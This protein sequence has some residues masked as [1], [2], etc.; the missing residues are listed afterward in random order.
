MWTRSAE[1]DYYLRHSHLIVAKAAVYDGLTGDVIAGFDDI[2]VTTGLVTMDASADF[3]R[4]STLTIHDDSG[5]K[6]PATFADALAPNG[7]EIQIWRGIVGPLIPEPELIPLGVFGVSTADIKSDV[8]GGVQID[9][10]A[11]DRGRRASLAK[12]TDSYVVAPN[13]NIATAIQTILQTALPDSLGI[14]Y[15][16]APTA[17]STGSAPLVY[18]VGDDPWK[19]ATD[20]A[21]SVGYWLY[22]NGVGNCILKPVPDP[23][24]A[25]IDWIYEEG[26][27]ATILTAEKKLDDTETFNGVVAIGSSTGITDQ[28]AAPVAATVW[29]TN[30]QSP[31]YYLGKFGKRPTVYQSDLITTPDQATAAATGILNAS[32][33]LAEDVQFTAIVNPAHEPG[34]IV[35][36]KVSKSKIDSRY[37]LDSFGIPLEES[38]QM[39]ATTRRRDLS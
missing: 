1:F 11:Y 26:A 31:T 17:F 21:T 9:L 30:P 38:G 12:F 8:E 34:D 5:E 24:T 18:N 36:V 2:S 6:T 3:Q 13:T 27:E 4:Q 22:F 29:D 28:Q 16:F 33:G 19:A 20:L 15:L 25:P 39:T 7:N 37:V 14:Q 32:L 23:A 35:S 10:T